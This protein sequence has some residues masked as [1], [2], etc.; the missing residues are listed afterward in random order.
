MSGGASGAEPLADEVALLTLGLAVAVESEL[1]R[2][3]PFQ[4]HRPL[5]FILVCRLQLLMYDISVWYQI[6]VAQVFLHFAH[7]E[8]LFPVLK[9]TKRS[10]KILVCQI[11]LQIINTHTQQVLK[12]SCQFW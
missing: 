5:L 8:A 4:Q 12:A 11:F 7:L 2:H 10:H 1:G 6:L 9:M 3:S